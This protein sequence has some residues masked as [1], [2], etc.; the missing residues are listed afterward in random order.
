MLEQPESSSRF[1]GDSIA[2]RM[3]FGKCFRALEMQEI[4][5]GLVKLSIEPGKLFS[6]RSGRMLCND[7][8]KRLSKCCILFLFPRFLIPRKLTCSGVGWVLTV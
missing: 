8:H 7:G 3:E 2:A 1:M 4:T 5:S 6:V